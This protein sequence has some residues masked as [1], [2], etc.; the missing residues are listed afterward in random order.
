M[1][2]SGVARS[3]P[4]EPGSQSDYRAR[5][6]QCRQH[7]PV[8][9]P[10]PSPCPKTSETFAFRLLPVASASWLLTC[11]NVRLATVPLRRFRRKYGL[12]VPCS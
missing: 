6:Y 10:C 8:L 11:G 1:A 4:G 2:F 9:R 7:V 12:W 3:L 5:D